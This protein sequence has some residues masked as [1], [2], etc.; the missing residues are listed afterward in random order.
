[1]VKK[2]FKR[3]IFVVGFLMCLFPL[4]SSIIQ[5]YYQKN[6]IATYNNYMSNTEEL[7]LEEYLN[8]ANEYNAALFENNGATASGINLSILKDY[9][10][11]LNIGNDVMASI[12]IPKISVNLPVYHGTSEKVLSSGVGHV[13]GSSLPIGGNNTRSILTAHRGLPNSKLFTRLD[14][15][16]EGDLFFIRVQNNTLQYKVNKIEVIDPE[17]VEALRI[18]EGKDLVS[19][20][21]CT[22]YGINTHRLVVTGERVPFEE[23]EY[24]NIDKKA[25]SYREMAFTI[26]PFAFLG[27]V[28][29]LK[30]KNKRSNVNKN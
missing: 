26:L 15:I 21:T 11:T 10:N 1:M 4:V 19:L 18:E 27:V 29:I 12:E 20:V 6:A 24:S 17:Q 13:Q 8:K 22:P 25:I 16:K 14:E 3:V 23:Q 2:Y 7:L 5:G 30:I 9:N 28:V